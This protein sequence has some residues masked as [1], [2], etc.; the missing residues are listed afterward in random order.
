MSLN[1]PSIRP[2]M[3]TVIARRHDEEQ[4]E[5]PMELQYLVATARWGEQPHDEG[6]HRCAQEGRIRWP[7]MPTVIALA[8]AEVI[9]E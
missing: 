6:D 5:D 1:R 3:P 8:A 9:I 7:E 2:E 4:G